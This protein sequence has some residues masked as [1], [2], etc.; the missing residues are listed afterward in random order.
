M[1]P[2]AL[3]RAL[4]LTGMSGIL[5]LLASCGLSCADVG[6][7]GGLLVQLAPLPSGSY[8]IDVVTERV[9][10]TIDF[11]V[12]P[13]VPGPAPPDLV[14]PDGTHLHESLLGD[15]LH[16]SY[17]YG[18]SPRPSRAELTVRYNGVEVGHASFTPSYDGDEPNG[19]GCGTEYRARVQMAL[20]FP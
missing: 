8:E 19:A 1:R 10:G 17:D 5:P 2:T 18:Y 12:P 6:Y 16:L 14:G 20:N 7:N 3:P 15:T 13:H 4:L 9:S 11:D